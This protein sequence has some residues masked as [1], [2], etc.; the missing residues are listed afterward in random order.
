MKIETSGYFNFTKSE[1]EELILGFKSRGKSFFQG[2]RNEIRTIE[3]R[4]KLLNVKSFKKPNRLNRYVYVFLRPSKA[5]R[6][7]KYASMLLSKGIKTPT[8]V[9]YGEKVTAGAL[10]ESYYISEHL[11]NDMTFRDLN[12]EEPEH[13]K[14]LREFT[15]FT[16]FLHENEVEFLDHSPGNTLIKLENG[17][18]EFFL[19]DL[20]RMNFKPLNFSERMK[21][22]ARL[23]QDER[24]FRIMANEYS[25]LIDESE[26]RIFKEMLHF[27]HSFFEKHRR[28]RR[29]KNKLKKVAGLK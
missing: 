13:E 3:A 21:N 2:P 18:A 8:P 11:D 23:S 9:A 10:E 24:V 19:V 26:A 16:Y 12:P 22:F 29:L 27:N 28:K 20:N 1:I 4:G 25:K 6:S 17:K 14:I 5:K 7:F 15:R